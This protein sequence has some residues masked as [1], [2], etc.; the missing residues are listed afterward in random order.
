M[1]TKSGYRLTTPNR[2]LPG[3]VSDPI[4]IT[5][6]SAPLSRPAADQPSDESPAGSSNQQHKGNSGADGIAST[7]NNKLYLGLAGVLIAIALY[8]V[9]IVLPGTVRSNLSQGTNAA[10]IDTGVAAD[11]TDAAGSGGSNSTSQ[12][13][14]SAGAAG[15]P[16]PISPFR[17]AQLARAKEQAEKELASFVELQIQLE[18]QLQIGTWG[19]SRYDAVKDLATQGDTAFQAR[20][21]ETALAT[22]RD[23]TQALEELRQGA[24]QDFADALAA[25]TQAIADFNQLLAQREFSQALQIKPDNAEA[26]AAMA[27]ADK[28][29]EIQTLLR[30]ARQL[31]RRGD[32]QAATKTYNEILQID[33]LTATVNEALAELSQAATLAD[34]QDHLSKGFAALENRR[35][36]KARAAFNKAL[37]IKP[38]DAVALGGLQQIAQETEVQ[39]LQNLQNAARNAVAEERWDDAVK[40]FDDAL[41]KDKNLAFAQSGRKDALERRRLSRGMNIIVSQSDKLSDNKRMQEAIAL[42][43]T[44]SE[45]ASSGPRW[46]ADLQRAQQTVKSYQQPVAVRLTSNNATLVTVYKV[47]RIGT[48]KTHDLELRPGAYTIVGSADGCQDVRKEVIVRPQMGPVE[49]VCERNL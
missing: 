15:S 10:D 2:E 1:Q 49:I 23:A 14:Q 21:F 24:E 25:G 42:L 44:A 41:S 46:T 43:Q 40:A 33:P 30:K 22:Y 36:T 13:D 9:F 20:E 7:R 5:P 28:L 8:W 37:G 26:L 17:D 32:T 38:G 34:Y 48:F 31:A 27:R 47:G 39:S 3:A 29:P 12:T 4:V 16:L 11:N 19:Q 6:R 35:Y 18:D 45:L